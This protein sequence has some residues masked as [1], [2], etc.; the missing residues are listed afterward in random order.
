MSFPSSEF[1]LVVASVPQISLTT[2]ALHISAF[3]VFFIVTILIDSIDILDD[4]SD[5]LHPSTAATTVAKAF[6]ALGYR[7]KQIRL[8]LSWK[9]LQAYALRNSSGI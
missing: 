9:V 3:F 7:R 8:A 6:H 2:R 1:L 4:S 5:V